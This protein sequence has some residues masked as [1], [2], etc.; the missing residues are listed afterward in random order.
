M[1]YREKLPNKL[2]Y[3]SKSKTTKLLAELQKKIENAEKE[4]TRLFEAKETNSALRGFTKTY[5]INGIDGYDG[6]SFFK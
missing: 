5:T 6:N 2:K 1:N 3:T 4:R